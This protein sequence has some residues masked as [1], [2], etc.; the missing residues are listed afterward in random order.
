MSHKLLLADDSATIQRVI[1]LTFADEDVD[2]VS[3][4]TG[5][6]AID[7]IK[8]EPPDIV[9]ADT[10]MPEFN[11]YE[12]AA[13]VKGDTASQHIPIVLLT[14]AFEPFDE[15]RAK[16]IG[17]SG[18][19]VKPFEPQ[20]VVSKVLELLTAR[21]AKGASSDGM[22]AASDSGGHTVLAQAFTTLLARELGKPLPGPVSVD[23]P[24]G[25]LGPV[26]TDTLV[27]E[28]VGRV[29]ERLTDQV[30]RETVTKIISRVAEEMVGDEIERVKANID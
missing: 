15:G 7:R 1:E 18:V 29:V 30:L 3:V 8:A 28:L 4:S 20:E 27:E 25:Q 13:F 12:V 16:S 19:L 21:A 17:C 14:G 26:L 23:V 2:V 22:P 10:E 6:Q 24:T 5:A 9:L 11:G